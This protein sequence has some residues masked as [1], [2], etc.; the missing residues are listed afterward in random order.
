MIDSFLDPL[1]DLGSASPLLLIVLIALEAVLSADN[2]IAL[3]AIAQGM[4][5]EKLRNRALNIGLV[6]AYVLRMGLILGAS[7]VVKY[8][9][10]QLL[11]ATY[12]LWLVFKYFTTEES[13]EDGDRGP[14]F[15]SLWQAVPTIA[16]TDLAFSLDS[17]AT[18]IAISDNTVLVVT[19]ATIGIVILRF[20]AGLFIKWL[21]EYTRLEDAGYVTIGLVGLR[22]SARAL[23][24]NIDIPEELIVLIIGLIFAWGFSKRKEKTIDN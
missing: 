14:Q 20:M 16:F 13:N 6:M 9:Q 18:A 23:L 17:V 3:A 2:A 5:D 4:D 22:L 24:P 7:W 10:F 11:G 15:D 19:G 8:W 1:S 21:D 12:L